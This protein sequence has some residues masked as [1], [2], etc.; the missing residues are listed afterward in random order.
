MTRLQYDQSAGHGIRCEAILYSPDEVFY[1]NDLQDCCNS[2]VIN[3]YLTLWTKII[4]A[5]S[6]KYDR[7]FSLP[8]FF[9]VD[10]LSQ[11]K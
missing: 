9:N 5:V 8:W 6:G 1:S 3:S 2:C 10:E 11:D 4:Y 7:K